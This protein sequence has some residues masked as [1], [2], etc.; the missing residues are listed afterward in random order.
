MAGVRQHISL[1]AAC[2]PIIVDDSDD[3]NARIRCSRIQ[4]EIQIGRQLAEWVTSNNA[5]AREDGTDEADE[6]IGI[7][8]ALAEG[9]AGVIDLTDDDYPAVTPIPPVP[10]REETE[11]ETYVLPNGLLLQAGMTVELKDALGAFG[12]RFL[13]IRTILQPPGNAAVLVRGWGFARTRQLHG[14]LPRKRNEVVQIMEINNS[15]RRS[16]KDQAL[17]DVPVTEIKGERELRITNAPFPDPSDYSGTGEVG[18]R[19]PLICR[20]RYCIHFNAGSQKPC[21]WALVRTDES[22]ADPE[23]RLP[24]E[25]LL[26]RWRGG[27]VPGGSHN[28]NGFN[29]PVVDL[30]S[31]QPNSVRPLALSFGQ[32]YTA[33][34]V[35]AG[36][37]GASRGIERAGVRLLFA[38]D[39]WEHAAESLSCNFPQ[40]D[41]YQMD[42]TDFITSTDIRYN[43]DI[44][45]LSPPCQFWSPA[46]TVAGKNDEHNIAVLFVCTDLIAKFRPRLF[47]V[48]Q[49]FG[50]LSPKFREFFNTFI[51]GFTTHGYSVRWKVVPLAN[52]GVPQLR[53]RLIMIGAC[54]GEKLPPLPPPT[55]SKGGVGGLKPWATPKSVLA[56][57]A[58]CR[59]NE[60]HRPERSRRFDPPKAPWE[61][62]QLARTITTNGGQ[63]YHWD[64]KR[65]FT[66]LEYAALQGF[67]TWHKF[68]G[69]YIKKQI[70]NAF[71]PS[72]VR[73]LYDHLVNWLLEQDG[74]D[75]STRSRARG[76]L[77]IDLTGDDSGSGDAEIT[78]LGSRASN[79]PSEISRQFSQTPQGSNAQGESMDLDDADDR[80]DTETLRPE[81]EE[82]DA[83]EIDGDVIDLITD[84]G[85]GSADDPY[86]LSD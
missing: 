34:D 30:E 60:L 13:R 86:E 70:G 85:R 64:G 35:F 77:P 7:E 55:H 19:A 73:V 49:T 11:L 78:C 15:D 82:H 67:P 51:N 61:P 57:L 83:M 84:R 9:I 1:E 25:H 47:T 21:E 3:F 56:P 72:V 41:V 33:G 32:Q 17:L 45:H 58:G 74:I 43:V 48:E 53:K 54:P 36:A 18:G 16:W 14:M 24:D 6:E 38:V 46:H 10:R 37:G 40:S 50:I 26:N 42:V 68:K 27:K 28:P 22:D 79:A 63:N 2:N 5:G 39:H 29:R 69:R 59:G 20:Y 44:L 62:N 81:E 12:V 75:P 66:L 76:D 31:D 71:A 52:Y 80:S 4:E 8:N 65:D 23:H